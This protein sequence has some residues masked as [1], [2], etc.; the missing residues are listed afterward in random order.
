VATS[1]AARSNSGKRRRTRG[2]VDQLPSGQWR[3]RFRTPD[4]RRLASTLP[5][6]ADADAW[7][8]AQVTDLGRGVWV[9][10]RRG[11]VKLGEYADAWLEQRGDLRPS[12]RQDYADI[13]RIH[14][15][16]RLGHQR[17]GSLS[18]ADVRA[19]HAELARG[20]PARAAKAY[21]VLRAILNTALADELIVRNPCRVRGGGG[22]HSPERPIATI[23]Q[24]DALADAIEE[25]LRALVLLAAWCGLRRG[26]LLGLRRRD[27]DLAAQHL[28]VERAIQHLKD[29]SPVVG[30]PKTAAG[31]RVVAIPPHILDDLADHLARWVNP[32]DEAPVFAGP[33]GRPLYPV[34]L[35]RAWQ[36]AR[37]AAGLTH[38]H[39]HDLRHT[40][41]TLA[42]ATGAS[43]RELMARM[44]HA[45]AQAALIYQ[46]ATA[47]RDRAIAT[48][49]SELAGHERKSRGDVTPQRPVVAPSD[50][51]IM[52]GSDDEDDATSRHQAPTEQ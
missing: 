37:Q 15:T 17:I 29:N 18:P 44:G 30:P 10:P 22:E 28:K 50:Q 43:T 26:E 27:I 8:S 19:W 32:S 20:G 40:G 52:S 6:K 16:P 41:N 24:V 38:L 42:A 31:R 23:A 11:R 4:G 34:A 12:T 3:A 47:D 21:R 7:L 48:A 25:R 9:D 33:S 51:L 49:L 5:T 13:I 14:I 45:S 39:L 35:N 36:R 1:S 2:A 46:H